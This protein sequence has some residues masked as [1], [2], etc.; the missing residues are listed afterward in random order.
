MNHD[1]AN[2]AGAAAIIAI[3]VAY[4]LLVLGALISVLKSRL[5]G[6]MKLVWCVFVFIA[7]FLGSLLWFFVGKK[8]AAARTY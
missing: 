5:E 6:G 8:S 3:P 7:P 4:G 2:V 1:F